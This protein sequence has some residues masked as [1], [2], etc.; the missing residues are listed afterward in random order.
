MRREQNW[1]GSEHLGGGQHQENVIYQAPSG[2]GSSSHTASLNKA[3]QVVYFS[4]GSFI[5]ALAFAVFMGLVTFLF[6][7][8]QKRL[9][10]H[11]MIPSVILYIFIYILSNIFLKSIVGQ[12]ILYQGMLTLA[13]GA[14]FVKFRNLQVIGMTGGIGCGKS[15]LTEQLKNSLSVRVL[16]CDKISHRLQ[17]PGQPC[18]DAIVN[19]FGVEILDDSKKIDRSK[20]RHLVFNNRS[21][22]KR[23]ERI[24]HIQIIKQLI[25]GIWDTF[26]W[27]TDSFVLIDAPLLYETGIL[28]WICYPIAVVYVSDEKAW[29]DRIKSRDNCSED[30]AKLKIKNQMPIQTKVAKAEIRVDNVG[31]PEDMLKSFGIQFVK[32]I[33]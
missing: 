30:D 11:V 32:Y 4:F 12:N 13:M 8:V 21:L 18:Y 19:E 2:I 29:L 10:T 14:T 27:A 9:R 6:I 17:E 3:S 33:S 1:M 20:L 24:T 5:F 22:K 7:L 25:F 28:E 15:T 16:D 26:F 31:K 23:L